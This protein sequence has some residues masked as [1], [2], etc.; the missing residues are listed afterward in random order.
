MASVRRLVAAA[1]L[2]AAFAAS[3]AAQT[4][5]PA[6]PGPAAAAQVASPVPTVIT[7]DARDAREVKNRL[8]EVLRQYPPSVAQ[9]LALDPTLLT[10]PAYMAA[11]PALASF[12]GQ[13]REITRDPAFYLATGFQ[14]LRLVERHGSG[15][16]GLAAIL[17]PVM[18]VGV[19]A[20]F[21][22]WLVRAVLVH[23]RW[24][25][26]SLLQRE[27]QAKLLDRLTSNE[28]LLAYLQGPGKALF[29]AAQMP[30][31]RFPSDSPTTRILWAVQVGLVLAFLGIGLQIARFAASS[32]QS[33]GVLFV[34]G[35]IAIAVGLGF[36]ASAGASILLTRKLGL[37]AAP[38][39]HENG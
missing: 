33:R 7:V 8:E 27:T 5:Q 15:V 38:R 35:V 34:L 13:H 21:T 30:S 17:F 22:A 29:D 4:P 28:E 3:A 2:T 31:L 10:S 11:Y 1:L 19:F 18:M 32:D 39:L 25:Q 36:V 24:K 37:M 12:V 9:V 6:S 20:G 14:R 26:A 23:R 16:E